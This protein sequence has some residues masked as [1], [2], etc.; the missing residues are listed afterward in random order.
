MMPITQ[1]EAD[2]Q[3]KHVGSRAIPIEQVVSV[4]PFVV[5]RRIAFRDCDPAGIVYTPRF[6]DPMATGAM[7]LFMME[8]TGPMEQRDPEMGDLGT[9]AKAVELLFHR[10]SPLGA[11]VDIT[12]DCTEIG[13]RTFTLGLEGAN[14]HGEALFSGKLTLI[15]IDRGSFTSIPLPEPLREKLAAYFREG[16]SE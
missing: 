7:D 1:L 10:G 12:V 16:N 13:N 15:C 2:D 8:L 6:L 4:K 11:M 14:A 5:R 3:A 9:P